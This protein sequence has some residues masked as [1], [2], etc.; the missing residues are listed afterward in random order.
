M[1]VDP[2]IAIAVLVGAFALGL[3]VA[4]NLQSRKG[5]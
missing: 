3:A 4:Y 2:L 5:D 1:L